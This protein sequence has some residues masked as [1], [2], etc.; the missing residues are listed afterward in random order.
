[1]I[2]YN[3]T[4]NGIY[5]LLRDKKNNNA[6]EASNIDIGVNHSSFSHGPCN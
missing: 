6:S 3:T 4:P 5:E 2:N 1:M